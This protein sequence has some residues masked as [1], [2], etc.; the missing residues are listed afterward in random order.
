LPEYTKKIVK[1]PHLYISLLTKSPKLPCVIFVHGGPGLNGALI[2]HLI[3][4][5]HIFSKL[6]YNI[7]VYDQR[8]CGRSKMT[9]E[10]VTHGDN[11]IDLGDVY[12]SL[13]TYLSSEVVAIMGHSYGAKLVFDYDQLSGFKIPMVLVSMAPSSITPRLTNLLL[14]LS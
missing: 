13:K 11:L 8:G 5:E 3:G 6:K 9:D 7:V 12:T 10:A 4:H 1:H 14:D 2:E